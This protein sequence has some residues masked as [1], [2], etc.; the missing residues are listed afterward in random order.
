MVR[1]EIW[2]DAGDTETIRLIERLGGKT[3]VEDAVAAVLPGRTVKLRVLTPGISGSVVFLASPETS[4]NRRRVS[5]VD[6]VLKVGPARLIAD[7]VERYDK[8]VAHVLAHASHFAPLDAPRNLTDLAKERPEDIQALHYRHVGHTTFGNRVTDLVAANDSAAVCRLID[9]VLT[10]LRP[11]QENVIT[12]TGESLVAEGIYSFGSDPFREYEAICERINAQTVGDRADRV[13]PEAFGRVR[14]LWQADALG[15]ERQL[16]TILHGDLHI[17]NILVDGNDSPTLID[18]GATGEGHFLRDLSTLEAHLLLRALAPAG[19]QV[20]VVHRRYIGDIEPLYSSRAFLEPSQQVGET[21][22][23]TAITRL[24]RYAFYCLM[25]G[26]AS[27]MPQYAFGVLRHAIRICMRAD[28]TYSDAQR[29]T[30]ARVTT[31]L[32]NLLAIE[33]H[34]LVI[35]DSVPGYPARELAFLDDPPHVGFGA[36][37]VSAPI[38]EP[39]TADQWQALA[40]AL[41][42]KRRVDLVGIVPAPLVSALLTT[43]PNSDHT[44]EALPQLRY[45]TLPTPP[46]SRMSG[47]QVASWRVALFGMRNLANLVLQAETRID[48]FTAVTES[49][50]TNC[51]I[52]AIAAGG[53]STI[54]FTSQVSGPGLLDNTFTLS[55][56]PD[57]SGQVSDMIDET[58][59]QARPFII[60]EVD[61]MPVDPLAVEANA[62]F[63]RAQ[64]FR[65][66]LYGDPAPR[67]PCLR[68][69]ALTIL[70]TRGPGG[71]QVLV[72]MR[73]PLADNDD[74]GRLSF[75]STRIRADDVAHAYGAELD[76]NDDA[77]YAFHELWEQ[78]GSPDPFV[79]SEEVF[80]EAAKRDVY[81]TTLLQLGAG[82]FTKRGF[83]IMARED[84]DI[85]LG[86]AVLTV[87]LAPTEVLSARRAARAIKDPNGALLR[88][89]KVADLL[90]GD[91][92]VNR[93]MR[94]RKEW[95]LDNCLGPQVT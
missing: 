78:I 72:K 69:I 81:E 3:T 60:R 21:A 29:W 14:D 32:R 27:Y 91:Y 49:V 63:M 82:R 28:D 66:S 62:T 23:G 47:P 6:G 33:N 1:A 11:W 31:M 15:S 53:G 20:S 9:S 76:S 56:L 39:C 84:A 44:E 73:S 48:R 38:A 30:A 37:G 79:L 19:D 85:Q 36:E 40:A 83:L 94:D 46:T 50:T 18:F 54:Y 80:T 65:L 10:I 55:V 61:C 42:V 59:A 67:D 71:R 70:R 12:I 75:L 25:R 89:M 68:P 90:S 45:V 74:F 8:W 43:W 92:P 57:A 77:E 51:V 13:D 41:R 93:I 88:D 5:E 26:D 4:Y 87:D 16:Q 34:R 86:F 22:L 35:R 52:R 7:E 64:A 95:L 17:D 2:W 24:R 58:F